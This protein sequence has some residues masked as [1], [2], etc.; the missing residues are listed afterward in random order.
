MFVPPGAGPGRDTAVGSVT[1]ARYSQTKLSELSCDLLQPIDLS[2]CPELQSPQPA[3]GGD[4]TNP[5][6]PF[7]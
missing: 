5:E 4:G 1:M 6:S 3:D 2:D 7:V